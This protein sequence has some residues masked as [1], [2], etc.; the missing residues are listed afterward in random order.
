MDREQQGQLDRSGRSVNELTKTLVDRMIAGELN[1]HLGYEKHEV[2]RIGSGNSRHG[3]S[4]KKLKGE[5]GEITVKAPRDRNGIVN[6]RVSRSS[7]RGSKS[8]MP[9]SC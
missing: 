8:S 9:R 6:R 2:A 7:N 5:A 1:H 3:K 4:Q